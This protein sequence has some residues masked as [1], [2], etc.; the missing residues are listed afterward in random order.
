MS[1]TPLLYSTAATV[2]AFAGAYALW[3]A[4]VWAGGDVKIFTALAA[5][6]P[7]NYFFLGSVF[8][9]KFPLFQTINLPIFPLT[10][11]VFSLLAI[12]PYAV[13]IS[14]IGVAKN[15]QLQIKMKEKFFSK[16]KQ[17]LLQ[18]IELSV[19]VTAIH[20]ILIFF[21]VPLSWPAFISGIEV[22]LP[23]KWIAG[24]VLLLIVSF[25][26][27]I[28]QLLVSLALMVFALIQSPVKA[29]TG[30]LSSIIIIFVLF[31]LLKTFLELLLLN[32][33]VLR[34]KIKITDLKE[35]DIPAE[36]IVLR[37]GK[38][39]R[40]KGLNWAKIIKYF[41]EY[42]LSAVKSLLQPEGRIIASSRSA[43]GV[44]P[45]QIDELK[46]LVQKK[47]L[48]NEIIVK[49]SAPL[50]PAVLIAFIALSLV[51]DLIW[52]LIF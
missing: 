14:A 26:P 43:A 5:L 50:A 8:G 47:K 21:N 49:L 28:F 29:I 13:I 42:N 35:G 7:L 17:R 39:E 46:N 24:L 37:Q 44:M 22:S 10:L 45:E 11:F 32:R 4:G 41:K 38:P 19:L 2:L 30:L 40:F 1:I 16:F 9:F 51:G 27:K 6:N 3:K 18:V 23:L 52:N 15:R 12:L 36:T 33:E 31:V 25:I 20:F 34:K 48:K